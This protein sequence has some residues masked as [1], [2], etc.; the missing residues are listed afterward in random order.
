[1]RGMANKHRSFGWVA[2]M[3]VFILAGC[4]PSASLP[5][6]GSVSMATM[7]SA[8][9]EPIVNPESAPPTPYLDMW[10][11][12]TNTY[13][14]VSLQHP[15]DWQPVPGYGSSETGDIRYEGVTGF[16]LVNAMDA[17]S[18]DLA[19]AS[20]AGHKLMPYG[21]NPTIETLVVQ[22][23]EARL[24]LPSSDQPGGMSHQAALIVT[25]PTAAGEI[26]F[27]R[28][29]VLYADAAHIRT[30]AETIRFSNP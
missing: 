3:G 8:V 20:E 23:Q 19:A 4:V 18:I 11:T 17:D 27:P 29:F 5:T 1:M 13:F 7:T 24:V 12:Y 10:S 28:F 26:R 25:Y 2:V 22:G 6:E 9:T 16:F 14:A 15:S 21:A 30:L